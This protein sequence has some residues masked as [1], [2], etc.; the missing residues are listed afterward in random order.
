MIIL[1][2]NFLLSNSYMFIDI[3]IKFVVQKKQIC[4]LW[5]ILKKNCLK[6]QNK[7]KK[8]TYSCLINLSWTPLLN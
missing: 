1:E 5:V 7:I 4:G 6:I 8:K 2:A 3:Q